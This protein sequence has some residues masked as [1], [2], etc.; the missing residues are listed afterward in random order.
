MHAQEIL[1]GHSVFLKEEIVFFLAGKVLVLVS[2]CPW[3][4]LEPWISPFLKSQ[5]KL[6]FSLL[7]TLKV[8]AARAV[9]SS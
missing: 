2:H 9:C 4:S 7:I 3:S 8:A 1:I 6:N 5:A